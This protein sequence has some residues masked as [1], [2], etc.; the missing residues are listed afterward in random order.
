MRYSSSRAMDERYA[1]D[2]IASLAWDADKLG[3]WIWD[4]RTNRSGQPI[5]TVEGDTEIAARFAYRA[6][7]ELGHELKGELRPGVPL[8]HT[9]GN[10]LCCSPWHLKPAPEGQSPRGERNRSKTRCR[11]GHP[12]SGPNRRRRPCGRRRCRTCHA[13][14][15]RASRRKRRQERV[16]LQKAEE[17][18]LQAL[19]RPFWEEGGVFQ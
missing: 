7:R 15:V 13:A 9:C 6:W 11:H 12:L 10:P 1:H 14:Q 17:E 16:R 18:S 5:L 3:C 4:G 8:L 19:Q 2:L